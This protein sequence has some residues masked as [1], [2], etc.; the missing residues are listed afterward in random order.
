M[1]ATK[2]KFLSDV[3]NIDFT[4]VTVLELKQILRKFG[5][6]STGKKAQLVERITEIS[7]FLKTEGRKRAKIEINDTAPE[8]EQNVL[9]CSAS[10]VSAHSSQ[11]SAS[12]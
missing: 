6:N 10:L 1:S 4:N 5:L 9:D 8:D 3:E 7:T 11:I 12:V 2:D